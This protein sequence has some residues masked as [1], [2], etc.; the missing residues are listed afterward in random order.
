MSPAESL[1]LRRG[2][3]S[4][5]DADGTADHAGSG[6]ATRRSRREPRGMRPDRLGGKAF[7]WDRSAQA[8]S[9]SQEIG[10][11]QL[12][13]SPS[14]GMHHV[15]PLRIGDQAKFPRSCADC[16]A[17][18][19]NPTERPLRH[20]PPP[21]RGVRAPQSRIRVLR[22]GGVV[23]T[24]RPRTSTAEEGNHGMS[25][26]VDYASLPNADRSA[27]LKIDAQRDFS[28]PSSPSRS[29]GV[30]KDSERSAESCLLRPSSPQTH[31][32]T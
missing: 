2:S 31:I 21:F 3:S 9:L 25:P 18:K 12:G 29:P 6:T 20:P 10:H 5:R 23:S 17:P 1:S 16:R 14:P 19:L 11:R 26:E 13:R 27:L 8:A 24:T 28:L 30:W 7:A 15:R 32:S 4:A 22:S